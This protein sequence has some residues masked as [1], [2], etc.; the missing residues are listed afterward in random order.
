VVAVISFV[1][2]GALWAEGRAG[3][4][5][6]TV[7]LI[8]PM[9]GEEAAYGESIRNAVQWKLE[10]H[11]N[12]KLIVED[13]GDVTSKIAMATKKLLSVD[14][15]DVLLTAYGRRA[16]VAAP[17]TEAQGVPM[18]TFGTWQTN[19]TKNPQC[20]F[21][22]GAVMQP[23]VALFMKVC[24][25]LG[26]KRLAYVGWQTPD[27]MAMTNY[28]KEVFPKNGLELV[29]MLQYTDDARDFRTILLKAVE[30]KPDAIFVIAFEPG[31]G[32][33]L[34]QCH[35]LGITTPLL[36]VEG[37]DNYESNE[38]VQNRWY[39]NIAQPKEAWAAAF[40]KRTGVAPMYGAAY[41]YDAMDLVL[42]ESA[43]F[44][45]KPTHAQ[46]TEALHKAGPLEGSV[47]RWVMRP[48][49]IME[50]PSKLYW[51]ADKKSRVVSLEE[52]K[53][54]EGK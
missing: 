17:M 1:A 53:K 14:K 54:L 29:E 44:K 36:T 41:A 12:W 20:T 26:Y 21:V 4:P 15:V 16:A 40:E 2:G 37:F 8:A 48:D 42:R 5:A 7:G 39:T 31:M 51:V 32:I 13:D 10:G 9:T 47:G 30:K 6:M 46:L 49:G 11:E 23:E 28:V 25:E 52:L 22:V 24:R 19:F 35:E 43:K 38:F 50:A 27:G 34:R 3:E 45:E 33:I 18:I